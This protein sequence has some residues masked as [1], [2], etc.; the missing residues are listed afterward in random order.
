MP[1]GRNQH[2]PSR[3]ITT[4]RL[5]LWYDGNRG[6]NQH[7]PSRGITTMPYMPSLT[8]KTL[9]GININPVAGLQ[10]NTLRRFALPVAGRNQH[11]PSRGITTISLISKVGLFIRRNQHQ[12]SRGITTLSYI[13]TPSALT[14]RNQHQPSRG[15]TTF[16]VTCFDCRLWK[17]ES[18]STQS[19][20]YNGKLV[21]VGSE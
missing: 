19:R 10:R 1:G 6:R 4:Y 20:D 11:Q 17:P 2:Q 5:Y 15:I 18:T 3:G 8:G 9:A 14:G 12:P 7:Q 13:L 16:V 21:D